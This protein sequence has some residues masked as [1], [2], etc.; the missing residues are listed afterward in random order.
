MYFPS[1]KEFL[2][3]AEQ[4]N[5]LPVYCEITGDTETPITLYKKVA[6][7]KESFLL[8]SVEG[9][10]KWARYS[11]IGHQ[12]ILL[13]RITGK[14]VEL[15]S[16]ASVEIR[17]VSSPFAYLRDLLR[18]FRAVDIPGLPRFFGG[19]VGYLSYDMV[20]FIEHLPCDK[21]DDVG[22]PDAIFMIP[23]QLLIYDNLSQTIKIVVNVHLREG[24]DRAGA[25]ERAAAEIEHTL[26]QLRSPIQTVPQMVSSCEPIHL[27]ANMERQRF[28][29][30]VR[31]AKQYITD[32]EAI[33]IVLSQRFHT[34]AEVNPFNVYRALRRVN[35][36]PYMYYLH[37]GEDVVVGASPEVLVRLENGR[38]ALRP[39][40]GTRPRGKDDREDAL[41]EQELLA[42]PK[43][44]AEHV[45]L[46]DLGRNDVGR[47]AAVGSV[48]VTDLM[49]VER[50]SHVMHLVSHV[51]GDLAQG[52]DMFDVLQACFPAGTV[53]GAPKVRAMEIIDELEPTRRGL[54]AGAVGYLGFTGNMDF[55]ITIRTLLM[56]R[57]RVYFQVGA[58]IVADSD[59]SREFDETVSKGR[60][61]V[62]ALEMAVSGLEEAPRA[63]R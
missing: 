16:N 47:V 21:P 42:D 39:I 62:R 46:V 17:E 7:G 29:E 26:E 45:M 23:A 32:G 6:T 43:E 50:Y 2:R 63:R 52:L 8:E 28:E 57:G 55:C 56:R 44:R 41:L 51:E 35:P 12:P 53:S 54:Y 33:Q 18:G 34:E 59:P 49:V 15:C 4:G 25:Y 3:L 40:A 20:R 5:I 11:F 58:G 31:R 27:T 37:F 36:S 19:L 38:I 30:M 24:E 22:M 1:K 9:G 10:E 60:A 48:E 61:L 14:R 13:A